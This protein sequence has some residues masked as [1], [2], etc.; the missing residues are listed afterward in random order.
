MSSK[1]ILLHTID[2]IKVQSYV[3]VLPDLRSSTSPLCYTCDGKCHEH[4][5]IGTFPPLTINGIHG[6]EILNALLFTPFP[7]H[8][9]HVL[10][11]PWSPFIWYLAYT[12]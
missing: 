8:V 9:G 4:G 1:V 10:Q 11:P 6:F 3:F 12:F 2:R 5:F 7:L